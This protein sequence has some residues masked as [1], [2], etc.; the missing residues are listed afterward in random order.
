L[1]IFN[2]QKNLPPLDRENKKTFRQT[3]LDNA[4]GQGFGL[5]TTWELFRLTRNYLKHGWTHEQ[6]REV[7]Y[8]HGHIEPIPTHY[9]FIGVIEHFW[10]K[11]GGASQFCKNTKMRSLIQEG[12]KNDN[13]YLNN[14]KLG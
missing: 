2:H 11:A 3:I 6:V 1:T 13:Q 5:L 10:E 4:E 12:F 8:R 9:E 7:F 14:F